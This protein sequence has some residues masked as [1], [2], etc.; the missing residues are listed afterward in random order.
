MFM[1]AMAQGIVGT[2]PPRATAEETRLLSV[3]DDALRNKEVLSVHI[4]V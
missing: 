2:A 4:Y 3:T 1:D